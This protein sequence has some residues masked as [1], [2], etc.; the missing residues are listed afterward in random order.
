MSFRE[1]LE[2][3]I[4]K[5]AIKIALPNVRQQRKWSCGH[6]ALRAIC[7]YF[8]LGPEDE[9]DYIKLLGGNP[10]DGIW[11]ERIIKKAKKLGFKIHAKTGMTVEELKK[12]LDNGIPVIC[13]IQAWGDPKYYKTKESGHYVVAIGYDKKKMYFEDPSIEGKRGWLSHKD[14]DERWH[15]MDAHGHDC[16]HMGIALW[17]YEGIADQTN[18]QDREAKRID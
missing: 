7:L 18:S 3:R 13:A 14:F 10:Q 2:G 1:W 9:K 11:P 12:F 15:D 5:K 4:P 16:D 17:T 8:G 6:S